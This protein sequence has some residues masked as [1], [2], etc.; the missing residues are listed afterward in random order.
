M[1]QLFKKMYPIEKLKQFLDLVCEEN[2]FQYI[3]NNV[4]FKR[5]QMYEHIQFLIND[6][7]NYYY[8]SK[9]FYLKRKLNLKT[10]CTILRQLCKMHD[11]PFS[12]KI[13]YSKSLYE[14]VYN[15]DKKYIL[16]KISSDCG[17]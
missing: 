14:I 10:F 13:L 16:E 7:Q 1:S 6:L 15:L 3:F 4:A 2:E 8:T 17:D 5:G 9:H 11:I 12:T